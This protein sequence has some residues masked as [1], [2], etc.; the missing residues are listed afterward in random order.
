MPNRDKSLLYPP[1]AE[2]LVRFEAQLAVRRLPFFLFEGLRTRAEQE[3]LYA[4]GRTA[5]GTNCY[6]RGSRLP[7][8]TCS[9]H[10]LGA[11]V[12]NAR[13]GQSIHQYGCAADYVEDGSIEQ[14]GIQWSWELK[15]DADMD[16]RG[17]WVEMVE[18]AEGHGLESASRWKSYPEFPHLQ[19]PMPINLTEM[20]ELYSLGGLELVWR[21]LDKYFA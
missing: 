3:L 4:K 21:E 20:Q 9:I 19:L 6:H 5:P 1:F 11:T 7:V 18:V 8:G 16:G 2:K 14:P 10:P 15:N 13:P 12:T 17:D